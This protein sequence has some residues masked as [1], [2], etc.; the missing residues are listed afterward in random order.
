MIQLAA[1]YRGVNRDIAK[2]PLE[3]VHAPSGRYRIA[4]P[5]LTAIDLVHCSARAVGWGNVVTVLRGLAPG[6]RP[7]RFRAVLAKEPAV[8][9]VA[10][11][12][13]LLDWLD[14]PDSAAALHR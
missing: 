9:D 10:R 8:A 12:S 11:L 14:V 2:A 5:E 13:Y 1:V 3:L 7:S 4:T 6:L